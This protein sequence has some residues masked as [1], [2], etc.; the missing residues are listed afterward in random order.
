MVATA[1]TLATLGLTSPATPAAQI[2][3]GVRSI[4]LHGSDPAQRSLPARR[5][6]PLSLLGVTWAEPRTELGGTAEVRTRD[7]ATGVCGR[8]PRDAASGGARDQIGLASAACR[9]SPGGVPHP[10]GMS[11]FNA[12]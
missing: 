7:R 1:V 4:A 12:A 6:E 10:H 3:A 9:M 11:K 8:A 2:P 5:T